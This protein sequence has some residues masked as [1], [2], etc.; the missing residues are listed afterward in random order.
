MMC[1]C[2]RCA[3][4]AAAMEDVRLVHVNDALADV[5]NEA[6]RIA[7]VHDCA[8]IAIEHLLHAMTG[9]ASSAEMLA[10]YGIDV[11]ALR[12]AAAVLIAARAGAGEWRAALPATDDDVVAALD[13]SIA[14]A[15]AAGFADAAPEDLLL[16][17]MRYQAAD[18]T[19][20]RLVKLLHVDVDPGHDDRHG[21]R[22]QRAAPTDVSRMR[23]PRTRP[24]DPD[25]HAILSARLARLEQQAEDDRQRLAHATKELS[26]Q[27]ERLPDADDWRAQ[28]QDL[29]MR[30]DLLNEADRR[31]N[32]GPKQHVTSLSLEDL[33]EAAA[34]ERRDLDRQLAVM[35]RAMDDQQREIERLAG[36]VARVVSS[37][38]IPAAATLHAAAEA[39]L[40][41]AGEHHGSRRRGSKRVR[42]RTRVRRH[43]AALSFARVS[44]MGLS[45]RP[46]RRERSWWRFLTD[47]IAW[48]A[49]RRR[50]G[51]FT[52][53][54][55]WQGG[56]ID[57]R[58]DRIE[59]APVAVPERSSDEAAKRFYLAIDDDIVDA[60][61]IGPKTAE[62]LRPARIFTVRDLLAA[63]PEEVAV[64]VTAR[65]ITADAV[66][67]W[68][69]QARLVITVPFLRGTHAQLLVGAGFRSPEAIIGADQASLMSA[70]LRF[71]T[72][73][74]G[75]SVL[76]NGPPPELDRIMAW[77]ANAAD[78]EPARAA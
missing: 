15:R 36:M 59:N 51:R 8:D 46:S 45:R 30:I 50:G 9:L 20:A 26:R 19:L 68:Q 77:K 17:L 33:R 6:Y 61:S 5:W 74:E 31:S 18:A 71:A 2:H 28:M 57:R 4:N 48:R 21:D 14:H 42:R 29:V 53:I 16:V 27:R 47:R 52:R 64:L 41:A 44:R 55:G 49:A 23:A 58:I 12:H 25:A 40:V 60:P 32:A 67:N 11:G 78:A 3:R 1:H 75:Q 7:A 24:P 38:R 65:H 10:A 39:S 69:D 56:A 43:V 54:A 35:S 73:R 34:R 66:R 70:I 72:T 37:P 13:L 63:D 62:R 76:R 22:G